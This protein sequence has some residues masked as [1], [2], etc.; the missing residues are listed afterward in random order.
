FQ[1]AEVKVAGKAS[2]WDMVG[3]G[4]TKKRRAF[5]PTCGAPVYMIFPDAPDIFIVKPASLD[6][7]ERYRPQMVT[8]TAAGQPWDHLDPAIPKVDKMPPAT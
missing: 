8:W 1:A 4:G 2:T 6:E 5:C 3:D 7:P